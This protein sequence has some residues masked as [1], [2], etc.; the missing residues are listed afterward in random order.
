MITK[1]KAACAAFSKVE[2][3]I[4]KSPRWSNET[5][6]HTITAGRTTF[7][8]T[9]IARPADPNPKSGDARYNIWEGPSEIWCGACRIPHPYKEMTWCKGCYS[10]FC[11]ACTRER[12]EGNKCAECRQS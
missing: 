10:Q 4:L 12:F 11:P 5:T 1:A 6:S 7:D 9:E 3:E 2:K 8:Q